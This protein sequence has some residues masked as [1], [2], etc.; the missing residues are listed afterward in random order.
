MK[1]YDKVHAWLCDSSFDILILGRRDNFAWVSEGN[2]NAVVTNIDTGVAYLVLY[3][4]KLTNDVIISDSSDAARIQDEQNSLGLTVFEIPWY[5]NLH[6]H[7]KNFCEDQSKKGMNCATDF[8][9]PNT[10]C[11][12]DLLI[13][14]RMQLN[15]NEILSYKQ[16][17]Q[18][19][20][21]IIERIAMSSKVG[22][23]EIS[24]ANRIKAECFS[25][26]ISPD[27]VLVGSDE[28]IV[29]YRHPMPTNKQISQSLMLVLGGQ[30]NGLNVSLT[31]MMYFKSIPIEIQERM[32]ATQ[33][34]FAMSQ[35]LM[36]DNRPYSDYF[37]ELKKA[38]A[39]VNYADE[40]KM[41]H[42]GGPTGYGCREFIINSGT[43]KMIKNNQA[44][45]WN[46]T[47]C[48]TKCEETSLLIDNKA[49][50][51]T[52]TTNW[53]RKVIETPLGNIDVASIHIDK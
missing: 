21:S 14:L 28:R 1:N 44:Y 4:N 36:K 9:I 51:I 6:T 45:A 53:P 38:Y 5:T 29:K 27:C 43:E 47:V 50:I 24:I 42:Q 34:I 19:C 23:S 10:T 26:N 15:Q 16:L 11:V 35:L 3:K 13:D 49:D 52:K 18:D 30:R 8:V 20:A 40:W 22:E 2:D 17:G 32:H 7:I 31:R 37:E 33:Y 39:E 46:P 41:H 25:K 12:L 48:G